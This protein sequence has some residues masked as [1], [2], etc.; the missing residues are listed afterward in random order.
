VLFGYCENIALDTSAY[1]CLV[2]F[3]VEKEGEKIGFY[4]LG[5]LKLM[6]G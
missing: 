1:S 5:G 2:L 6:I 4:T 3:F